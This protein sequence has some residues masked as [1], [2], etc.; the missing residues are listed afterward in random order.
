MADPGATGPGTGMTE[1]NTI[2][3]ILLG[4]FGKFTDPN[5]VKILDTTTANTVVKLY[6][7]FLGVLRDADM[8]ITQENNV[9]YAKFYIYIRH[10]IFKLYSVKADLGIEQGLDATK[11]TD[12]KFKDQIKTYVTEF[13]LYVK[14]DDTKVKDEIYDDTVINT[15]NGFKI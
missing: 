9:T 7:T 3:D 15:I 10:I 6:N 12:D 11:Y 14:K 2:V 8:L 4:V 13:N 1:L 5:D